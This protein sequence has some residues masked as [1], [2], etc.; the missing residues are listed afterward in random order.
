MRRPMAS[1][2]LPLNILRL[3]MVHFR[4]ILKRFQLPMRKRPHFF[5][6]IYSQKPPIHHITEA[7]RKDYR[8][9][10][11]KPEEN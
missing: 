5:A 11:N 4:P 2:Y 6:T 8:L 10:V 7:A 3:F 9:L 1:L